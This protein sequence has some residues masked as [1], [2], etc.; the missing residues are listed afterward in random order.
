M[1]QEYFLMLFYYKT[2]Y[3]G[4]FLPPENNINSIGYEHLRKENYKKALTFFTLNTNNYPGSSNA[5][6]SLGEV[7]MLMGDKENAI[8]H[9]KKSLA[10]DH[11]NENAKKMIGKLETE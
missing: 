8:H 6:D 2:N 1:V 10:L 7:Y 3:N 9:Y 11:S 4:A 5:F